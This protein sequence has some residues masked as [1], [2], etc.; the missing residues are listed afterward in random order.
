MCVNTFHILLESYLLLGI[1]LLYSVSDFLSKN[2]DT[3]YRDSI[4][5]FVLLDE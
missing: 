3:E 4:K 1:Y 2:E 5:I